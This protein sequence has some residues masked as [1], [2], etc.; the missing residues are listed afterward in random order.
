M[1]RSP[2]GDLATNR[3][4][5]APASARAHVFAP[6]H[7][8]LQAVVQ[9]ERGVLQEYSSI[10]YRMP[11]SIRERLT[12][13]AKLCPENGLAVQRINPFGAG[14]WEGECQEIGK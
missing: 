10:L 5:D 6:L 4:Q 11:A 2:R 9:T 12:P 3:H 1:T 14:L 7:I 13:L 8:D